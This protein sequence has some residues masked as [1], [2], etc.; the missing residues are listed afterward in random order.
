MAEKHRV[1]IIGGGFGGLQAAL[2]LKPG[3]VEAT[4]VDRRNFHLFQPLLYQVATGSLSPANIATPLRHILKH[5]PHV[6]VLMGEVTEIDVP[7]KRVLLGERELSYETLIVAAG[8]THHYFGHEDWG[9]FAPGLKTIEDATEIRRKVLT[10]FESAEGEA[11][12]GKARA[13]LT[14]VVVGAGPTGVELAGALG[15]IARDTLKNEF[16]SIDPT[17]AIIMLVEGEGRIL[18]PYPPELSQRAQEKLSRLGV[19]CRLKTQV[20]GVAEGVLTVRVGDQTER[21]ETHTVLWAAGIKASPLAATL[22]RQTGAMLDRLQR[23][24][25]NLDLTLP[26]Y[27]EIFIIGDMAAFTYPASQA[28]PSTAPVAVQEG[29]YAARLIESRLKGKTLPSF[30]YS[31]RGQMA[32]VGR[33]SAVAQI[34]WLKLWGY[35]A[36][37]L[38]LFVH[39]MQLVEFENR[40]LVLIQ[41][42]WNYFTRN[43]SAR[44]ITGREKGY[45]DRPA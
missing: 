34:G 4:L 36:W 31:H 7:H 1:V 37:L 35:M 22:S 39:L 40:L 8:S 9:T 33:T 42:A 38:W 25:V 24:E 30:H 14:F 41:W 5:R 44:L 18:Q 3:L 45:G 23:L 12:S 10:A 28:L 21:I 26:G 17:R 16:K 2:S 29:R 15:D 13:W 32:T 43:R 19:T 20:I 27:P 11:D 6:H